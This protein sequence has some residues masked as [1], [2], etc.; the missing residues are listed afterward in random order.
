MNQPSFTKNCSVTFA[1]AL[2]ILALGALPHLAQAQT[3]GVT[4]SFTDGTG[5]GAIPLDQFPGSGDTGWAAAWDKKINAV[6]IMVGP[7]V[8]TNPPDGSPLNN[9]GNYLS[10]MVGGNNSAS[11]NRP[12]LQAASGG[13]VDNFVPY[14]FEWD[15][16]VDAFVTNTAAGTA[17]GTNFG[18]SAFSTKNDF[19][20]L[21]EN[22]AIDTAGSFNRSGKNAF[23][24]K[25]QGGTTSAIPSLARNFWSF[26]DGSFQG[27]SDTS[28]LFVNSTNVPYNITNTYHFKV[29]VDP[30]DR[31]W[32]GSVT[33]LQTGAGFDTLIAT[34]RKLRW[35]TVTPSVG[36]A[37]AM[38]YFNITANE[39]A[40]T[41][42]NLMSLD[43]LTIYQ[44]NRDIWPVLVTNLGPTRATPFNGI[45]AF[46]G[47]PFWPAS[48]NFSFSVTTRGLTN[49]IPAASTHLYLNGADVTSSLTISGSD[50][51]TNRVFTFSGLKPDKNYNS[52]IVAADQAGR[53]TTN[54][55]FFDTFQDANSLIIEAE[56]FNFAPDTNAFPVC[57]A[58]QDQVLTD[59][60]IQNWNYGGSV[61]HVSFYTNLDTSY[62][63]R[64]GAPNVDFW[65]GTDGTGGNFRTCMAGSTD[66][67]NE[68]SGD[69][70]RP[71][72]STQVV[73]PFNPP[74][75]LTAFKDNTIRNVQTNWWWNYTH[76]W[77]ATNY[78]AFL[79]GGAT[80][81]TNYVYELDQVVENG[82]S[83]YTNSTQSSNYL[84]QFNVSRQLQIQLTNTPL[85]DAQGL[86]KILPLNGKT[87]LKV[88][89]VKGGNNASSTSGASTWSSMIFVPVP[90]ITITNPALTG[91]TFSFQFNGVGRAKYLVE[92]KNSLLDPAWSTLGAVTSVVDTAVGPD[93]LTTVTDSTG[94]SSR[95]YRVRIP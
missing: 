43:G 22:A 73:D 80:A 17:P 77:P 39:N 14:V 31:T 52:L 23:W 91:S 64:P 5:T 89:V 81:F 72:F 74:N 87:T 54:K 86:T 9:G 75:T 53:I 93:A 69:Q 66:I 55:M 36:D 47:S 57:D 71:I 26:F 90:P 1:G 35:R 84:A 68:L 32:S 16:R 40:A 12:F 70:L 7:N 2:C 50:S 61:G 6:D 51:D 63:G 27:T 19:I 83:S 13:Q 15:F 10:W 11:I 24:I 30:I 88:A 49:T 29:T 65:M 92:Y 4:N 18:L 37:T 79:R 76:E 44:V 85:T 67:N 20:C 56:N 28:G 60:Y 8:V 82:T 42:S 95:L 94:G 34:G 45:D 59:R 41:S 38:N 48:S 58:N 33:N 78:V 21:T 3:P 46:A 25:T 62:Y